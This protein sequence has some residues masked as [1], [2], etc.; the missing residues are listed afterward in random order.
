MTAVRDFN[1]STSRLAGAVLA[2]LITVFPF[3]RIGDAVAI[4]SRY[5]VP[6][7]VSPSPR[8]SRSQVAPE[9]L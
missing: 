5:L 3:R 6:V 1:E 7:I 8:C 9:R 4:A 2:Y